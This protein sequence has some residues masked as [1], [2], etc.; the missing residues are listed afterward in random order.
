VRR[1]L[2]G[3]GFT[4]DGPIPAIPDEVRVE[5]SRRYIAAYE[6]I[7]GEPFVPDEEAPLPRLKKNLASLFG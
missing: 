6:A 4:G 5:A 3:V 1:W 7:V 2:A